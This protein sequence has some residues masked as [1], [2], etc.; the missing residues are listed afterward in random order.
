MN[1]VPLLSLALLA[2]IAFLP[3]TV[4]HAAD[5]SGSDD[6]YND[7]S[8]NGGDQNNTPSQSLSPAPQS[9]TPSPSE[10]QK[11][12]SAP[13]PSGGSNSSTPPDDS[14]DKGYGGSDSGY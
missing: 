1:K 11:K 14:N 4:L 6:M 2:T 12:E 8:P 3:A 10:D 13:P 9:S 7:G 5:N